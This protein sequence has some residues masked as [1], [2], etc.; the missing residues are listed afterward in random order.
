MLLHGDNNAT[1][2]FVH[3]TTT[4]TNTVL[5]RLC[6]AMELFHGSSRKPNFASDQKS[7]GVTHLIPAGS[8]TWSLLYVVVHTL[9]DQDMI[10]TIQ[11]G[12]LGSFYEVS[13]PTTVTLPRLDRP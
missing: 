3:L 9:D 5:S 1:I 6:G 7:F 12:Y 13:F 8:K 10:K 4:Y 2:R 11:S